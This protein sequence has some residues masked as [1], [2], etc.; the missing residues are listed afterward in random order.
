MTEIIDL[1]LKDLL[2]QYF[3]SISE[4]TISLQKIEN[5]IKQSQAQ[6]KSILDSLKDIVWSVSL[7]SFQYIYLNKTAED[8]YGI[9]ISEFFKNSNLWLEMVHPED[10][11]NIKQL[12]RNWD[13]S[14]INK[15][16][17][18]RIIR[19]DG[20]IRWLHNRIQVI[21][22]E[23]KNPFVLMELLRILRNEKNRNRFTTK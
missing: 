5:G 19:P 23:Q 16:I 14:D 11:S 3:L 7:P 9:S 6:L 15:D 13:Q 8:I 10:R 20:Q 2:S 18:Y 4:D 22:N 21:Y 12:A 1:Y 17:E